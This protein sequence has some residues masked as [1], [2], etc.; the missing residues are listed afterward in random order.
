MK[1]MKVHRAPNNRAYSMEVNQILK[2]L[3]V[4]ARHYHPP[5]KIDSNLS[6]NSY[7]SVPVNT[8]QTEDLK[9][10]SKSKYI[11]EKEKILKMSTEEICDV[12]IDS[13]GN[14]IVQEVFKL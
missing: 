2:P 1:P 10:M 11:K 13:N 14:Y 9:L 8:N 6:I 4:T 12:I 7:R 3:K 5:K